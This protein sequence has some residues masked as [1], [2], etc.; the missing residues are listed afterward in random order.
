IEVASDV[1]DAG[2]VYSWS[3]RVV[4]DV[5]TGGRCPLVAKFVQR[6]RRDDSRVRADVRARICLGITTVSRVV[7][8]CTAGG[9]VVVPIEKVPEIER[10]VSG[11]LPIDFFD[12]DVPTH[13]SCEAARSSDLCVTQLDTSWEIRAEPRNAPIVSCQNVIDNVGIRLRDRDDTERVCTE[14][15]VG[16]KKEEFVFLDWTTDRAT[17]LLL[18]EVR[19]KVGRIGLV[20]VNEEIVGC[21]R[22]IANVIE[23]AAVN[24]VGAGF[25]NRIHHS[26][27]GPSK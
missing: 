21:E 22:T 25:Q 5:A 8:Q 11:R 2:N 18:P 9:A 3:D 12:K 19:L 13:G 14:M 1:S 24:V 15:L 16:T 17:E 23:R 26:T 27:A 20:R 4:N 6:M 7:I 10:I